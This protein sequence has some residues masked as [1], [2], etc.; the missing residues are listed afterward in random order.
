[1]RKL[2]EAVESAQQVIEAKGPVDV[3]GYPYEEGQEIAM[4]KSSY[5]QASG[6]H[7]E[8]RTVSRVKDGKV[9]VAGS[10]GTGN[11]LLRNPHNAAIL[12]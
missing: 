12:D 11:Y 4:A 1:M 9:Y 3:R 2:M 5:S 6:A 7:I 8:I 10:N